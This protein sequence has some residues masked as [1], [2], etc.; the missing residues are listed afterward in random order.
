M[1][2][3]E[4]LTAARKLADDCHDALLRTLK[5]K[6]HH[7]TTDREAA[8]VYDRTGTVFQHDLAELSRDIKHYLIL[9]DHTEPLVR[10]VWRKFLEL[11]TMLEA[12]RLAQNS[13][14]TY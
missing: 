3:E 8:E 6:K 4:K 1:D 13:H 9:D 2:E 11:E 5:V 12:A 14:I 10:L 7:W